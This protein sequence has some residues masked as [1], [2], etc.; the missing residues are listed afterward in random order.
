MVQQLH[1]KETQEKGKPEKEAHALESAGLTTMCQALCTVTGKEFEL[2]SERKQQALQEAGSKLLVHGYTA[3]DVLDFSSYWQQA[4][5]IGSR[6]HAGRPHL[7]QVLED[8]PA[9]RAWAQ[10]ERQRQ[11]EAA[12]WQAEEASCEPEHVVDALALALWQELAMQLRLR[13]WGHP[14][15]ADVNAARPLALQEDILTVQLP[16]ADRVARWQQRLQ[17]PLRQA[18]KALQSPCQVRFVAPTPSTL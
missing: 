7:T 14:A 6:P 9:A 12:A 16:Y 3:A 2:L 13:L 1:P 10:D 11:A 4:H 5:Y 17:R 8:M 18:I 15:V